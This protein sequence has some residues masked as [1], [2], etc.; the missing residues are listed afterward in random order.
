MERYIMVDGDVLDAVVNF[1][2]DVT[3][4]LTWMK[5]PSKALTAGF[6]SENNWP[7]GSVATRKVF[8]C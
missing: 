4:I 2:M 3:K 5:W 7:S 1:E 8:N 6:Y